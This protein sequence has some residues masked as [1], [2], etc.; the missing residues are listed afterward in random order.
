MKAVHFSP[1]TQLPRESFRVAI[2]QSSMN[3][4][5]A[6]PLPSQL[7]THNSQL[8][9]HYTLFTLQ[10]SLFLLLSIKL[11]PQSANIPLNSHAEQLLQR[12]EI[13]T[14]KLHNELFTD[15]RAY[16]RDEAKALLL[17]IDSLQH[18]SK[19]DAMNISFLHASLLSND[20]P[21]DS[22]KA[23]LKNFYQSKA[24][25]FQVNTPDLELYINPALHLMAGN[26]SDYE[27]TPFTNT[28]AV[29]LHGSIAGKVGFYSFLSE[30]Q[31]RVAPHERNFV[32]TWGS[33]P[34]AHLTKGFR[35]NGIDFLQARGYI[36]F[37]PVKPIR[38]QFGQDR[39][40]IGHGIRSLFVS[41]F[42]T[43]Y[44]FLKI[45]T[46]VWR[47]NYQN[48]YMRL[49]DRYGYVAGN[50]NTARP[51]PAKFVS[52][53]YLSLD[54]TTKLN[55]GFFEAVTFHDN[56]KD[57]RGFDINYLNPIIFYRSIEHQLGDAD[58]ML[59]GLN[60]GWLP[61]KNIQ[62][63]GQLAINEWRFSD[64]A[65][66][67]GHSANKFGW[68]AGMNYINVA[69][70]SNLDL[71]LEYNRIRPYT[72]T[73]YTHQNDLWPVNN[74]SHHNQPLAHP[75][76]ANLHEILL[77]IKAQ[78]LPKLH[79]TLNLISTRYGA[80]S[81]NSNWGGNIHLDYRTAEQELNNTVGQ[82][83]ATNLLIAE[84]ILSYH[85]RHNLFIEL[86][87][88]YRNL[89]SDIQTR[90]TQ[91]ILVSTALRLNLPH[92]PWTF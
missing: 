29:E 19:A 83:V 2:S 86:D 54:I 7:T 89:Q 14:G 46:R 16:N 61:L 31:M 78:P 47:F 77:R 38:I 63:Y 67:N 33:Y 36:T 3:Q 51:Y 35:N 79:A 56:N 4:P 24:N 12:Y 48:L 15:L 18:Q 71:Q 90:N 75:M 25:L 37:S 8:T 42:A 84:A 44:L 5:Y 41:D 21:Y 17:R 30:N 81:S 11:F 64:L 55:I 57:G 68:Q 62:V 92:R 82:G 80:D 32:N 88:R 1:L 72:Y 49:N 74:Y 66:G 9:L 85:L 73:H 50:S 59:I 22:K 6:A 58:K 70:I 76:G 53:H 13:A 28:R 43:D 60:L 69:G 27:H 52:A 23:F 91:N 34:G 10:L 39:N 40:F 26:L 87:L 65:A 45:N 20:Q